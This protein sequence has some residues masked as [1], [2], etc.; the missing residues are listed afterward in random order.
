[1][2]GP[3]V[4]VLRRVLGFIILPNLVFF[5]VS[6]FLFLDRPLINLDYAVLGVVWTALPKALRVGLFAFA[7]IVDVITATGSMYNIN[8]VAGIVALFR[9]PI[10]LIITVVLVFAASC[11]IAAVLGWL[12][13][14]LVRKKTNANLEAILTAI[15]SLALVASL[16]DRS[17]VAKF[18]TDIIERD[19]GY[20][21]TPQRM[22]AATDNLR[23]DVAVQAENVAIVVMESWGVLSDKDAHARLVALFESPA[24]DARYRVNSGVIPF[25]GGTTSG[26]LRELC[27]VFTDYLVLNESTIDACIPNQLRQ[28]GFV[29]TALHGY[30]PEYYSRH[31]WYPKLFDRLLFE[32][33]LASSDKRCGTQFRGICDAEVFET[34]KRE[35]QSPDTTKRLTYWLTIDAHTPVDKD[36]MAELAQSPNRTTA[37]A[38]P[39]FSLVVYFW[40]ETLNRVATLAADPA[41][42]PTRFIIVGDH[43]PAFVRQSRAGRLLKGH[44]PYV[45][46]VPRP[47]TERLL[48]VGVD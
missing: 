13:D 17:A 22:R 33:S 36:R 46:L 42:P 6:R 47:A 10:G 18:T 37:P 35:V 39:D 11:A 24:I 38:P 19:R 23:G 14:K 3:T 44:V 32:D 4:G 31:R 25:R 43:A 29:A 8:P 34:F 21:T 28:R 41:T 45:E 27:G 40:R 9:A 48:R 5:L 30:K 26:E 15:V 2:R 1:M 12:L 16:P 20:R 7:F